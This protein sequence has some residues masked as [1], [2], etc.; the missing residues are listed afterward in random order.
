MEGFR[1]PYRFDRSRNKGGVLIYIREDVP[2]KILNH[3]R[4]QDDIEAIFSEI[5]LKETK[6]LICGKH[7]PPS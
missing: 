2:S 3:R 1:K 7:H 5:S 4:Y 6:W